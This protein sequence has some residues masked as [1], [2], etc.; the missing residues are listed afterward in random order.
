MHKQWRV[1]SSAKGQARKLAGELGV[2]ELVA[3]LMV[4]RGIRN[5]A[6]GKKFLNPQA[7]PW[8]DP[9][10]LRD[11]RTAV[12][13][14]REAIE[15]R[16]KIVVYGDYDADGMTAT[17]ILVRTL[18]HFQADVSFYIPNRQR[19]GYGLNYSALLRLAD[20]GARLVI[21][22]D[23]GI[24]S[25][26]E[27]RS[28]APQLDLIITD[29]HLPGAE[30]PAA[31]A[32]VN[33]HRADEVYPEKNLC[34]AGVAFKLSQALRQELD[35]APGEYDADLAALG[36]V[37][38]IV[39]LL[40]E[41][42]KLVALGLARMQSTG[43]LGLRALIKAAAL[44]GKKLGTGHLGFNLAP[45]LNAVGRLGDAMRGVQLLITE[46]EA[47]A[48]KLAGEL[49]QLNNERQT[50]EKAILAEA[51]QEIAAQGGAGKVIVVARPGW[52]LGVVGLVASRLTEKHYRPTVV[53][54]I[55]DNG[56]AVGSCRSIRGFHIFD[57][58]SAFSNNLLRYGGHAMA[59]GLTLAAD[60]IDA[61]RDHLTH[62]ADTHLRDEDYVPTQSLDALLSP[63]ELTFPLLND[64]AKMAPHGAGNPTPLFGCR[65]LT[66]ASVSTM[67]ANGKHL[68]M[69]L[70]DGC[71]G[72]R[73]I[74]WSMGEQLALAQT[75]P[76]DLVYAPEMSEWQGRWRIEAIV[77]DMQESASRNVFP[78]RD[79]LARIYST[80]SKITRDGV[81]TGNEAT[82][83]A[84]CRVSAQTLR[85]A[86]AVFG[87]LGLVL[88]DG[89][90]LRLPPATTKRD[91]NDSPTFKSGT[92]L[93]AEIQ[94]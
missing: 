46:D 9:F 33:P 36:T 20:A 74:G 22:V 50:A 27:A 82:W 68:Q 35:G 54:G 81:V 69:Q 5:A 90:A 64:L 21:T 72:V 83:S 91:L 26:T 63:T 39:P 53:L 32:V 6:S 18:R 77:K 49:N 78:T 59:A 40:D 4:A 80:L 31:V 89:D 66:P 45:R 17:A 48:D 62:W 71:S 3:Q 13:R 51:E 23:C 11:L 19:E 73:A 16:E 60:Q 75:G 43:N 34:G 84:L 8:Y 57:A 58:L 79:V 87:E 10:I 41:N 93:A 12:T 67:G 85:T 30:L 2:S 44:D 70:G 94:R 55:A 88:R 56:N 76:V 1:R 25:L 29:H 92:N 7:Q 28:I 61:L 42:R 38:D 14:I 24:L 37:A 65:E 47:E 15:R 86:L 52:N